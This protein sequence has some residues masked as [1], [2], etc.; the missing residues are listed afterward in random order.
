L[1]QSNHG[2]TRA[3]HIKSIRIFGR[4]GGDGSLSKGSGSSVFPALQWTKELE[5]Q[6]VVTAQQG[7]DF[8]LVDD[9]ESGYTEWTG[10]G[11]R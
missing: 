9:N 8:R 1:H 6:I 11:F 2:N 7:Q 4:N 3:G 10:R 5:A